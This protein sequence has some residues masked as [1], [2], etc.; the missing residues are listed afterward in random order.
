M[1]DMKDFAKLCDDLLVIA[2]NQ[3]RE[4][5][6]PAQKQPWIEL[7][8]VLSQ[9]R[10]MTP[11]EASYE[12]M[13]PPETVAAKFA[14]V[15]EPAEKDGFP[16]FTVTSSSVTEGAFASEV[17]RPWGKFFAITVGE[18]GRGR[19]LGLIPLIPCTADVKKE[20]SVR[21]TSQLDNT[22][23]TCL[24]SEDKKLLKNGTVLAVIRATHGFRGG[25]TIEGDDGSPFP[26]E[27]VAYGDIADG[28]AGR[29]GGCR[30]VIAFL[31]EGD[32]FAISRTGRL[33]GA[34]S[35]VLFKVK[36]GKIIGPVVPEE[37][38]LAGI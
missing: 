21:N 20:E 34:P 6:T 17:E 38:E 25:A 36:G 13:F 8:R 27:I 35:R 4:A 23:F 24:T 3:A 15:Q 9:V 22:F 18:E 32:V 26:G 28:D 1:K 2:D 29:M 37:R 31:R 12:E 16:I 19:S 33:Y 14:A 7:A 11:H 5:L 30:Q 10:G